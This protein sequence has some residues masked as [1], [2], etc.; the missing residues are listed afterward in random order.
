[1]DVKGAVICFQKYVLGR[2]WEDGFLTP[3]GP[4]C[5]GYMGRVDVQKVYKFKDYL[6]IASKRGAEYACTRKQLL[7]YQI[8][9]KFDQAIGIAEYHKGDGSDTPDLNS[10]QLPFYSLRTR[11]PSALGCCSVLNISQRLQTNSLKENAKLLNDNLKKV[12]ARLREAGMDL[13]FAITGLLGGEDFC[14]I[15]LSDCFK[16]ISEAVSEIQKILSVAEDT[17]ENIPLVDNTHSMLMIDCSGKE[18]EWGDARA[19]IFFSTRSK[20][21]ISYLSNVYHQ[22]CGSNNK[23]D[24]SFE[25]CYGEYDAVIRCPARLLTRD[26]YCGQ[27][28]LLSY[29]NPDYQI[30]VYQSETIVYPFGCGLL[31]EKQLAA[32]DSV[33]LDQNLNGFM[34]RNM[35]EITRNILGEKKDKYQVLAY[36][37]LTLY[38]LLKDY[39]RIMADPFN[40]R[41]HADL[42]LQF[43][44]AVNAIVVA[45]RSCGAGSGGVI[46]FEL[47]DFNNKFDLII[48][49]LNNTMLIGGQVD[50]FYFNEQPSYL[51]NTGSYHKILLAYYGFIKDVL[52]LLYSVKRDGKSS[53]S[54]L[55]PLLSFGLTPIINSQSFS[56]CIRKEGE[57]QEIPAKLLCIKLPYQAL[58]NPPKYLGILV[59]EIFHYL[60]PPWVDVWNKSLAAGLARIAICEFTGILATGLSDVFVAQ[61]FSSRFYQTYA[62]LVDSV[63]EQTIEEIFS[64]NEWLGGACPDHLRSALFEWFD[65]HRI[66]ETAS[67]KFY[68]R[69]WKNVHI[70]LCSVDVDPVVRKLFELDETDDLDG[71]FAR[72]VQSVPDFYPLRNLLSCYF[73]AMAEVV[74]DLFDVGTVLH[75]QSKA[76]WAKQ[77]FWQIYSTQ[78]DLLLGGEAA[79]PLS[80]PDAGLL[81]ANVI[82]FGILM[83]YFLGPGTPESRGNRFAEVLKEWCLDAN[84]Q[85]RFERAQTAFRR[86]YKIYLAFESFYTDRERKF[87]DMVCAATESVAETPNGAEI[88]EKIS[89]F[90]L[91][92]CKLMGDSHKKDKDHE[93]LNGDGFDLCADFIAA[94][95]IQSDIRDLKVS[96]P[97][98]PSPYQPAAAAPA[99]TPILTPWPWKQYAEYPAELS[100]AV[101]SACKAMAVNGKVP[102]LWY[103]GQRNKHSETLPGILREKYGKT[104][105]SV[106]T[107][108]RQELRFARAQILPLGADFTKAGWLAFLQHHGFSTNILDFSESFYP[109]LYFAIHR[110]IEKPEELPE[111][112]SHIS[113]LNPVLFNLAMCALDERDT[114]ETDGEPLFQRL[115]K[116]LQEGTLED[117]VYLQIPLFSQ[118]EDGNEDDYKYY[119]SW[120]EA[121]ASDLK[122]QRP[123]AAFIPRNSERMRRQ[124]GQFVFYDLRDGER[125]SMEKLCEEY[126]ELVTERGLQPIPFLYKININR[127]A[128]KSFVDYAKAIGL[129]KYQ[130]YPEVENLAKDVAALVKERDTGTVNK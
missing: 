80:E 56:S 114:E 77:F 110:W 37:E 97:P 1:M 61:N 101:S 63:A 102:L 70:Q 21:G 24:I 34:E 78:S 58:A 120:D 26:L 91:R 71:A 121:A 5:L 6:E 69:I 8:D 118:D 49:A 85:N 81:L 60:D 84:D 27:N 43:E 64:R 15:F 88:I 25:G 33:H 119:F 39:R 127:F 23:V 65:F 41:L 20:A 54:L 13:D 14:L 76:E 36:I 62:E 98:A 75:G 28:G 51:Q 66:P 105:C 95:Q 117:G 32:K 86:D 47:N 92:Y 93:K 122:P 87:L 128:H 22:L 72:R 100:H 42:T 106:L 90:Y 2:S 46:S 103:R 74:A 10:G 16:A 45:S 18:C 19:Q 123:R 40:V 94:Y 38:R 130:V 17:G 111:Y 50:R 53:Q 9:R 31:P 79:A 113:L 125:P 4:V 44:T 104:D 52:Q 108:F 11:K 67:Y 82:R 83:D 109:S 126:M 48:N 35:R 107:R 29:D 12:Q 96:V 89:R 59:H 124:T 57:E 30:S 68:C 112:D 116:Y 129:R 55:V 7:I 115:A 3:G 73:G 99:P